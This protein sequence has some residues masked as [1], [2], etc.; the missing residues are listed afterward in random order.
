MSADADFQRP[1]PNTLRCSDCRHI[2]FEGERRHHYADEHGEVSEEDD[3]EVVCALCMHQRRRSAP[4]TDD[5]E[6]V[7]YW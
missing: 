3:A 4:E 1:H 7:T 2:W 6:G 5:S